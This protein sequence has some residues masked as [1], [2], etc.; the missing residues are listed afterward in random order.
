MLF[1]IHGHIFPAIIVE[2]ISLCVCV[3]G[4]GNEMLLRVR[5]RAHHDEDEVVHVRASL[6]HSQASSPDPHA[7][8]PPL[9]AHTGNVTV[10]FATQTPDTSLEG[11]TSDM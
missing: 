11:K 7:P 1:R 4:L 8:P 5:A 3:H 6:P 10:L 9:P 2:M